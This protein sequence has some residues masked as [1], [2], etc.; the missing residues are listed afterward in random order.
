MTTFHP[1]F[2]GL[3]PKLGGLGSA[4][5]VLSFDIAKGIRLLYI[6]YLLHTRNGSQF[7]LI[8]DKSGPILIYALAC[9]INIIVIDQ[10]LFF[11]TWAHKFLFY[12]VPI[13]LSGAN[14][15]VLLLRKTTL[16]SGIALLGCLSDIEHSPGAFLKRQRAFFVLD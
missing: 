2:N 5:L 10:Y 4:P 9:P 7:L 6:D 16:I 12:R 14:V 8:N 11:I 15:E 13:D 1:S 3:I